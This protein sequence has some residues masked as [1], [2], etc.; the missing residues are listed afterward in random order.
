MED[1]Y[2]NKGIIVPSIPEGDFYILEDYQGINKA[3]IPFG[4]YNDENYIDNDFS[5]FSA[6]LVE[7]IKMASIIEDAWG[8]LLPLLSINL[9]PRLGIIERP[10]EVN[11]G[12]PL[13]EPWLIKSVDWGGWLDGDFVYPPGTTEDKKDTYELNVFD[14][15][16][17]WD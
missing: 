12:R 16:P 13:Y 5:I 10:G 11:S 15:S 9:Y 14:L 4:I 17:W 7:E 6:L 1:V 3:Q 8:V 2:F